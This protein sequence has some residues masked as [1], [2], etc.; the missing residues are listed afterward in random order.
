[1]ILLDTNVLS[2]VLKPKPSEAVLRWLSH[3]EPLATFTTTITQAEILYG[4]ELLPAGKRKVKLSTAIRQMFAEEFEGLILPFDGEA[5]EVYAQIVAGRGA[6]GR[7]ISQFD[8][9]IAAIAR[10]RRI[11]L[12]TRNSPDFEGCGVQVIN[13]WT[14]KPA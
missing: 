7:P 1:M 8:A 9:M 5:A 10:S 11:A 12:A 2:E 6:A 3:Q 14:T 13:P 4:I